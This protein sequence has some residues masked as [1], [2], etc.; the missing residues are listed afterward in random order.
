MAMREDPTPTGTKGTCYV[1]FTYDIGLS[2]NLDEA[3]RHITAIKQRSRIRHKRRAP[4]YFDYR[5][6]PLRVTQ[7]VEPLA[8]GDFR[9]ATSVD[10]VV[11]DFGAVSVIY[12]IP[13]EGPFLRLLALSQVLYENVLLLADSRQRVEDLQKAIEGMVERPKI[14]DYVEDYVIFHVDGA[15]PPDVLRKSEDLARILRSEEDV[16][17][18]QEVREATSCW[19]SF[20]KEDA[21]I[22]D[23]NAALLFG[24]DMEDVQAVLEFANVELL[25]MRSLDQQL[26]DALD[27]AYDALSKRMGRRF[28]R[29]GSFEADLRHIAQLQVDSA[30]L[31]E[32][33]TNTLKLI[34]DQYLARVYRLA[35][36]RFHLAAWDAGILRKLETLDS[37]YGKMADRAAT[38]RMEVLEWIIIVLITVSITISLLPGMS[39]H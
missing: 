30:I 24:N 25:E 34:G 20:G 15:P 23:W 32:R 1:L 11:Y 14:S 39:S 9:T 8:L 6:A 37:I 10:L 16:L 4:Q 36:E 17:S 18:E 5:P 12:S 3:E 13:L 35:S 19:L 2:I 38:R 26:D 33:V 22:I 31:F 29:P 28:R 21:A 27:Q 7:G